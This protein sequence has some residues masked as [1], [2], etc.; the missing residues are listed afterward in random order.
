METKDIKK[1]IKN[2]QP[3]NQVPID[4]LNYLSKNIFYKKIEI[5]EQIIEFN[6]I[7]EFIPVLLKGSLRLL[8]FD[9]YDNPITLSEESQLIGWST[10]L[11][12]KCDISG[13]CF[14]ASEI[15]F[16]PTMQFISLINL[17]HQEIY[18]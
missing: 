18:F 5:G 1:R 7:P 3:L 16:I 10:V 14:F 8:V 15:L 9:E 2:I 4:A 17:S 12:G 6:K 13:N 11:R